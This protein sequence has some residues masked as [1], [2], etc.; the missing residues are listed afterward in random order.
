MS[1]ME[2]VIS[3]S[4]GRSATESADDSTAE[5]IQDI[6]TGVLH[7]YRKKKVLCQSMFLGAGSPQLDT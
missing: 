7:N 1:L 3:H 6:R 4:L 2:R 5:K